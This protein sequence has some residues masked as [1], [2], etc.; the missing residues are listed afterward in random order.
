MNHPP[1]RPFARTLVI[2]TR[3]IVSRLR[4]LLVQPI[5]IVLALLDAAC[6]LFGAGGLWLLEHGTNPKLH[7]MLDPLWWAV[8]T[9]TTVGYGD[10]QPITLGGKILG[11][12]MMVLGTA[13]FW[14][15]TAFF[16]GALVSAEIADVEV[17]VKE[18]EKDVV[19]I[20]REMRSDQTALEDLIGRMEATLDEL[21]KIASRPVTGEH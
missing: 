12:A 4:S 6:V 11:I 9:V 3:A 10:V 13:F 8:A 1:Q 15:F 14:S 16:A 5:F 17:E 20:E 7:T 21:K 19:G 2:G 18:L